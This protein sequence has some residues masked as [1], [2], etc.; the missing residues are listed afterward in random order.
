M[1]VLLSSSHVA[2]NCR[3]KQGCLALRS[4]LCPATSPEVFILLLL[5]RIA[6][7]T[8]GAQAAL[9]G[10]RRN[11]KQKE[12]KRNT[13]HVTYVTF[14]TPL[15]RPIDKQAE[16]FI[17]VKSVYSPVFSTALEIRSLPLRACQRN[18]LACKRNLT[19]EIFWKVPGFSSPGV[20]KI[21]PVLDG[22]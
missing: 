6:D 2:S 5:V 10:A 8:E 17:S 14:A 12:K 1:Q 21:I 9:Q 22:S 13:Q 19:S 16:Q 7:V 15:L 3:T 20:L 4:M 11:C 18:I